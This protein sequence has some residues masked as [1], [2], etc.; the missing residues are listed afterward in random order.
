M[1]FA[2]DWQTTK[3]ERACDLHATRLISWSTSHQFTV[4]LSLLLYF[5]ASSDNTKLSDPNGPLSMTVPSSSIESANA[6]V[7][8]VIKTEESESF[9]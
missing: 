2:A 7:K 5:K 1:V 6:E 9:D 3:I 8:R 4:E